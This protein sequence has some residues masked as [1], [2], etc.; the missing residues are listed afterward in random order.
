[1][2]RFENRF[3]EYAYRVA[4]LPL[5]ANVKVEEGQ[6]VTVK[7]GELVLANSTD[8]KAFIAIGSNREGRDQV[9]G[10]FIRKISFLVGDFMLT[11][12]NFKT[13][14]TYEDM[15]P[16]KVVDGNLEPVKSA[17]AAT[18]TVVAYAL[19]APVNGFLRIV[20]A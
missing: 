13:S 3:D 11:V 14:E 9:A 16:L 12:S 6:W 4:S 5:A 8:K 15:A 10:K 18:A 20:S 2:I 1:M 17:E 19:G 7:K